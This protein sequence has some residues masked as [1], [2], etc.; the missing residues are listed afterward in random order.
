M[1]TLVLF[2]LVGFS[3]LICGEF[4]SA[5]D[6]LKE[7]VINEESLIEE[8]EWLIMELETNLEFTKMKLRDIKAEHSLIGIDYISNPLNAFLIIKRATTESKLI[9]TKFERTLE[10]FSRKVFLLTPQ[11]NELAGAVEGLTRL[12]E[13]YGL[14][15]EDLA[16]GIIDGTKYRDELKPHDLYVIA[17]QLMIVN[18][19][20]LGIEYLNLALKAFED[21]NNN[22]EYIETIVLLKLVEAHNA[23]EQ[24]EEVVSDLDRILRINPDNEKVQLL[25]MEFELYLIMKPEVVP[26]QNDDNDDEDMEKNGEWSYNKEFMLYAGVCSGNIVSSDK[27]IALLRCRYISNSPFSLLARFKVEEASL[28]PYVVLFIDVITD[29][30]SE[31]LKRISKSKFIRAQIIV[32]GTT[33]VEES[34]IRVAKLAWLP[35]MENEI[36]ARISRRVEDMTGLTTSSSEELQTQNYGIG[37]HYELHYDFTPKTDEPFTTNTGNRIAT[38]LF[39]LS[40]VE[41]GGATVFPYIKVRIQPKKGAAAFWYNLHTSG[42]GEYLT[43]HAACPVLVGSKW[44]ANKWLH[45]HGQ[46][47]RR[48]CDLKYTETSEDFFKD[49]F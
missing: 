19:F 3:G 11:D 15:S 13:T 45:E 16:N 14:S 43:R 7:L 17:D 37:G 33:A 28:Q 29:D 6:D 1:Q 12:Q 4:Y 9:Q 18:R 42:A 40:D 31:E 44:V 8:W 21:P 32:N 5:V 30:E 46:E 27:E 23:T 38:V 36:V 26:D 49:F 22:D 48:P 39:Y 2:I 25:K 41:K 10:D 24:Y 34:N 47:Q 20:D 35:D